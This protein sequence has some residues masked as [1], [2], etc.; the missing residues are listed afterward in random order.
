VD[1]GAFLASIVVV[2]AFSYVP[3]E[4]LGSCKLGEFMEMG[5]VR[6]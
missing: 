4:T 5:A 6:A 2:L 1:S 3:V